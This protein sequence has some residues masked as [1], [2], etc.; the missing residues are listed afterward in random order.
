M[1]NA[2]KIRDGEWGDK[3]WRLGRYSQPSDRTTVKSC[4]PRVQLLCTTQGGGAIFQNTAD[5]AADA[6]QGRSPSMGFR[7]EGGIGENDLGMYQKEHPRGSL[8]QIMLGWPGGRVAGW[9]GGRVAGWPGGRVAGWP[10]GR[11]AGP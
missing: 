3:E 1:G 9:P 5:A 6:E 7:C 11:V 10:G 2:N 8:H 4:N